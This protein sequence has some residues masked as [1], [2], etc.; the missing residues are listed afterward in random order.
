[1]VASVTGS[2]ITIKNGEQAVAFEVRKQ[3]TDGTMGEV[4]YFL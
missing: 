3:S 2:E 4:V 1:M